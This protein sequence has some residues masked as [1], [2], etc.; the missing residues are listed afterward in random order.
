MAQLDDWGGNQR[1]PARMG[2]RTWGWGTNA[3]RLALTKWTVNGF[4]FDTTDA[5][6]YQN[7]GTYNSPTWSQAVVDGTTFSGEVIVFAG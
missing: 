5:I 1:S 7:T 2:E 6:I 3:Q 4:F